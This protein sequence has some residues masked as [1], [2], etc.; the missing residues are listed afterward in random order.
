ML[1]MFR[2]LRGSKGS[3]SPPSLL[4]FFCLSTFITFLNVAS[5]TFI[6]VGFFALYNATIT[7]VMLGY[8]M[9]YYEKIFYQRITLL[10]SSGDATKPREHGS[11]SLAH[12]L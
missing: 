1:E 3:K 9:I 10:E 8:I 7:M 6:P 12:F 5:G 11:R 4:F 2:S